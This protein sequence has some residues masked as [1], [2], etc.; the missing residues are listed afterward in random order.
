MIITIREFEKK[1][2]E[3]GLV[4]VLQEVWYIIHITDS[5]LEKFL[6]EKNYLYV[7]VI[8]NEVIGCA[9]LHTQQKLIRNGGIAGFIEDVAVLEKHRGANIGSELIQ[10]LI[11]KAKQL[12]CYKVVLSCFPERENFYKRNGFVNESINMRHNLQ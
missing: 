2:L 3:R 6:N 4:K 1:D 5:I 7:A 8:N 12:G 10:A 11:S 9:T